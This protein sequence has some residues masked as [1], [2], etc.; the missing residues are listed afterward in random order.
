MGSRNLRDLLQSGRAG[1]S[2]S[3]VNVSDISMDDL[4]VCKTHQTVPLKWEHFAYKL[5]LIE[6][7]VDFFFF[8][9]KCP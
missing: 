2:D 1:F 7:K 5:C 6:V 8:L 3:R 4:R 9:N